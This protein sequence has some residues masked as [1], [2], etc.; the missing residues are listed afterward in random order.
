[1]TDQRPIVEK[2]LNLVVAVPAG[3]IS[4]AATDLPTAVAGVRSRLEN[5]VKVAHWIGEMAVTTGRQELERRFRPTPPQPATTNVAGQGHGVSGPSATA[6]VR[7]SA[8]TCR[9]PFEGYDELAAAQIVQLLP[10][11]PHADL[12]L[13]HDYEAAGRSRR[14]ILHR[15]QQL[16]GE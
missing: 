14:T 9:P 2:V 8:S 3:L 10:R 13:I 15:I 11:L 5:K 6:A 1:M 16:V 4:R 7:P 12:R